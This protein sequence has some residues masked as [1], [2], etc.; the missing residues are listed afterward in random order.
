MTN[1][2]LPLPVIPKRP[3]RS[4]AL[5]W[6]ETLFNIGGSSDRCL[7][8]KSSTLINGVWAR[9]RGSVCRRTDGFD[10]G[11]RFFGKIEVFYNALDGA[12]RESVGQTE[13][14]EHVGRH[15]SDQAQEQSRSDTPDTRSS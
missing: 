3:I 15:T 13:Q 5:S 12:G 14:L 6:N 9:A 8:T 10:D 2:D 4:L 1:V 7:I 11:R